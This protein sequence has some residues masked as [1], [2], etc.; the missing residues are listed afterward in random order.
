MR[1]LSYSAAISALLL[2][3]TACSRDMGSVPHSATIGIAGKW[4]AGAPSGTVQPIGAPSSFAHLGIRD[5]EKI[6]HAFMWCSDKSIRIQIQLYNATFSTV[7]VYKPEDTKWV[8]GV[9]LIARNDGG[10]RG[11]FFLAEQSVSQG[12]IY[13]ALL[14]KWYR[15]SA[16]EHI[17]TD[18]SDGGKLVL[19]VDSA[20]LDISA[21]CSVDR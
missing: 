2:G 8:N 4:E 16:S 17:E 11:H 5:R 9:Y 14:P 21:Q 7:P 15:G 10:S 1:T 12:N 3:L 13:N 6:A 19:P 18:F 20:F